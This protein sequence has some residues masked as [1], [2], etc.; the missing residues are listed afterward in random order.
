[1]ARRGLGSPQVGL[2]VD[3]H[4]VVVSVDLGQADIGLAVGADGDDDGDPGLDHLLHL[5][6]QFT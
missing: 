5:G 6:T 2:T 1:M 3:G 4:D